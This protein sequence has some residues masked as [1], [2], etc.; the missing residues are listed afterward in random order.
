MFGAWEGT[1][2]Q[3]LERRR[4]ARRREWVAL[5]GVV[6]RAEQRMTE[7]VREAEDDGDINA[8]GCASS[9]EWIAQLSNTD[10]RNAKCLATTSNALR[11]LPALD[12]AL[13]NG[14]LNLDQVT[15][16]ATHATPATDADCDALAKKAL[17]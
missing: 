5:R 13:S 9:A 12:T 15:A 7:I 6:T 4:E 8:A 10:Y 11:S 1:V 3:A 16:A 2:D 14:A 17:R